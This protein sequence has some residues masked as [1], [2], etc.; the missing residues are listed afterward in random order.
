MRICVEIFLQRT[1]PTPR[2]HGTSRATDSR[3]MLQNLDLLDKTYLM[4]KSK[5]PFKQLTHTNMIGWG[6]WSNQSVQ[7]C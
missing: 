4:V 5:L 7:T 2:L 1:I 6:H 3:S